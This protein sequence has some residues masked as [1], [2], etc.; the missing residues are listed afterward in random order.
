MVLHC[1][2]DDFDLHSHVQIFPFRVGDLNDDPNQNRKQ[3]MEVISIRNKQ[4]HRENK[5]L[6][7]MRRKQRD[8][9]ADTS[10]VMVLH[11]V[12]DDFDLHSHVQIFPFRVG[13]LNA[14]A[15]SKSTGRT[16]DWSKCGANS[17]MYS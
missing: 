5:R 3:L 9:L 17:A 12:F 2:F 10:P 7:Q 11:C 15:I 8:V 14:F 1:V 13:D 4:I 6:E 16:S